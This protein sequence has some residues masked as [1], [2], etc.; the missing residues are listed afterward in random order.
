MCS[1]QPQQTPH[2]E[3]FVER[4]PEEP[5]QRD[6]EPGEVKEEHAAYVFIKILQPQFLT[7][8]LTMMTVSRTRRSQNRLTTLNPSTQNSAKP[9]NSQLHKA[10]WSKS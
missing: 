3:E 8:A 9:F 7:T 6:L 2:N 4:A 10:C 5:S 1:Q